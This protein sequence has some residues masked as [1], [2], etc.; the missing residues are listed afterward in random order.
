MA[1]QIPRARP[2]EVLPSSRMRDVTKDTSINNPSK[3]INT[4]KTNDLPKK[5]SSHEPSTQNHF[6]DWKFVHTS[7]TFSAHL[8]GQGTPASNLN[9]INLAIRAYKEGL[10]LAD[11]LLG[12]IEPTEIYA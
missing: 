7:V 2:S 12:S 9:G 4:I 3:K 1:Q 10:V 11:G 5:V 6:N 8:L